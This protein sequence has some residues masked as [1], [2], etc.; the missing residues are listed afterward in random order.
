MIEQ[1]PLALVLYDRVM[2]GPAHYWVEDYALISE[3]AVRIVADTIAQH[4]AV[5]GR[6][7]EVVLAIILVHPRSLEESVWIASLQGLSV[8]IYYQH[9]AWSLGKLQHIVAHLHHEA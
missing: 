9:A 5:A 8:L 4:V 7:A 3:W 2:G 1:E 6:I